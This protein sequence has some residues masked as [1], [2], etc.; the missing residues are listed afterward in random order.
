MAEK[1]ECIFCKIAK[2]EIPAKFLYED[3]NFVVF[4]DANPVSE[5]HCLIVPK[6]HYATLLDL[7]SSLGGEL[8]SIAKAQGLRLIK[9]KK[10]DG[11][12]LVNNNF[13]ASGQIVKHFHLHM[14]PEKLGVKR[15]KHV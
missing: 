9:E 3:D 12:K 2:G 11:F 8:L 6:K 13:E 10:A 15:E 4:N 1:E 14:I 5:G 7:P